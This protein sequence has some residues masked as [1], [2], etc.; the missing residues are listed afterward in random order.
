MIK[1]YGHVPAWGVPDISPYVTKMDCYLRMTGLPYDLVIGDLNTAPKG[2]LPYIEDGVA[3]VADTSFI[4]EYL[5]GTYG[6]T[7]D[8]DLTPEQSAV[9]FTFW[10]LMDESFYWC[11]VQ[12]RYRRD[13]DFKLYDPLWARFFGHLPLSE[14]KPAIL[15]ARER[16]LVEFYQSGRGRHSYDE[17]EHIACKEVEAVSTYLGD[18]NFLFGDQPTSADAAVYGFFSNLIYVPF[19]SGVKTYA[20]S[21]PNIVAYMERISQTYY[22][23]LRDARREYLNG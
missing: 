4:L 12:S 23:K 15:D 11:L 3:T 8:C 21:L 13:E 19:P 14:R 18:K 2:K 6:D 1:M 9:A 7:L 16:L 17:V 5:K 10:R 20:I 22:P